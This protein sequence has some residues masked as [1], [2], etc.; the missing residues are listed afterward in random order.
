[1]SS[2][3]KMLSVVLAQSAQ[4]S[5]TGQRRQQ[6]PALG[7]PDDFVAGM[8]LVLSIDSKRLVVRSC[9]KNVQNT[10]GFLSV[11]NKRLRPYERSP[12]SKNAGDAGTSGQETQ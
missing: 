6:S 2:W 3:V 10:V 5:R 9:I 12:E 1:V 7:V 11:R 8:V 4:S